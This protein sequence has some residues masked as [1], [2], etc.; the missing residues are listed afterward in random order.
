MNGAEFSSLKA[1]IAEASRLLGRKVSYVCLTQKLRYREAVDLGGVTVSLERPSGET[2][3]SRVTGTGPG[4]ATA[5]GGRRRSEMVAREIALMKIISEHDRVY[6]GDG[7]LEALA[8]SIRWHGMINPVLVKES[9]SGAYRLIAGRRRVKAAAMAGLTKVPATVLGPGE[10]EAEAELALAENVNRLEM[11][12]LDEA[13][14]FAGLLAKG[15]DVK[16]L[17]LRYERSTAAI[18]QRARL[19]KLGGDLR[20]LFRKGKLTLS[21]AAVLAGFDGETQE[22]FFREHG[23]KASISTWHINSFLY[24]AQH[25]SL[26]GIADGECG[27]CARRTRNTDPQLFEDYSQ[28]K[29]VCFDEGCWK[30]KWERR[31]YGLIDAAR[32]GR[33]GVRTIVCEDS[34]RLPGFLTEMLTVEEGEKTIKLAGEEF[35]VLR[36]GDYEEAGEDEE[37]SVEAICIRMWYTPPMRIKRYVKQGAGTETVRDER[38][39]KIAEFIPDVPAADAPA[40]EKAVTEKH[41]SHWGFEDA[42]RERLLENY[43]RSAAGKEPR[44]AFIDEYFKDPFREAGRLK[45]L[46]AAYAGKKFPG[47]SRAF[48]EQSP[49]AVFFVLWMSGV[50]TGDLPGRNR[51]DDVEWLKK[52]RFMKLTGLTAEEYQGLYRD[53]ARELAEEAALGGVT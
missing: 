31:L 6:G 36:G 5:P 18:Y 22:A 3:I 32:E 12:P 1:G 35:L 11:D 53:A 13:E 21:Q 23:K 8:E 9:G 26:E 46:Y 20:D 25:C 52:N 49:A 7:D 44:A 51:T 28:Y 48:K 45:T 41:R 40:L 27:E 4:S 30:R 24:E 34:C 47:Y 33:D 39:V 16:E 2:Y 29:D 38:K 15:E 14:T 50:H 10:E 43:V 17:A 42:V 19:S 37:G